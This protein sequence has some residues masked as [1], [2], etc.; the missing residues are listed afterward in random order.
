MIHVLFALVLASASFDLDM[1]AQDKKKTGIYKLSDQEKSAL[2]E[3]VDNANNKPMLKKANPSLS[4]N[5]Y[6]SSYLKLTD[7]SIWNVRPQDMPIS[8]GWISEVEIIITPS[9]DPQYPSKLTNSVSSSSVLARKV[10][11]I[12]TQPKSPS[13][14]PAKKN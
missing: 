2:Q 6:N 4:E 10:D 5:L 14:T 8:Q 7:N 11:S 1:S 9:G 12:P 13:L 3:W